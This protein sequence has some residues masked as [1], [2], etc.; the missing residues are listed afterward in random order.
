MNKIYIATVFLPLNSLNS[1]VEK[2][3]EDMGIKGFFPVYETREEADKIIDEVGM[4]IV[5]DM[6]RGEPISK[7]GAI[8]E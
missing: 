1:K 5:I 8:N 3:L 7:R 2:I 4:G 6:A